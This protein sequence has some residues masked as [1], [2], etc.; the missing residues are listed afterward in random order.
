MLE[1]HHLDPALAE[2]IAGLVSK[3]ELGAFFAPTSQAEV[4]LGAVLPN[5]QRFAGRVD[6]LVVRPNDIWVLDYKTDWN[7]PES[8]SETHSYVVQMAAYAVALT[9][10][11]PGKP[12]KTALLWTNVPRLDWISDEMLRD[13]RSRIAGIA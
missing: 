13:A 12:I 2:K 5:G 10:A 7:V 11:Y 1:K 3:P 8:L 9:Q 6:R 4:S